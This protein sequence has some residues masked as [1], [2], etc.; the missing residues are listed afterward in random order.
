[1]NHADIGIV[2]LGVMGAALARNFHSRGLTVATYNREP[3]GTAAFRAHYGDARYH[4]CDDYPTFVAALQPPRRILV[5]VTAGPAID[6]VLEALAPSLSPDDIVIDGGNSFYTDTQ[7]RDAWCRARGFRFVGMGVSGGEEG[8]L[9]GPA[10]MA[11]GDREA[12]LRLQP[13]LELACARSDSG[14]C[15]DYCGS[16]GA[17]HF[18]KMVHN[19]IEY[20]DMQLIA[21]VWTLL[22]EGMGL[23]PGATADVFAAWNATELESYLIEIT[24]LVSGARDPQGPGALV[25][26]IRDVAGPHD[27]ALAACTAR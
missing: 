6:A 19:G 27:P 15:V 16:G 12:W 14:A 2:G 23:A 9:R 18:V 3:E 24:A 5:M 7:R 22:R 26:A 17:G 8:A 4:L 20:G 21:E 1:M 11:G 10:M 25:D 13:V